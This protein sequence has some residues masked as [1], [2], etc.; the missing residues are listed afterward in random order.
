[1][2]TAI[3][4]WAEWDD[5]K[6]NIYHR[7]RGKCFYCPEPADD[8]HHRTPNRQ[9]VAVCRRCHLLSQAIRDT[10][11]EVRNDTNQAIHR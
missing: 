10:M 5:N 6:A 9:L 11:M 3:L 4:K 7:Q 1:M 2:T 8:Y